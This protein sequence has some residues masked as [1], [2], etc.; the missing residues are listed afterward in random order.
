MDYY[1]VLGVPKNASQDQ[2]KKQYRKLSLEYHP[3]RPGGNANKFKDINEA[4]E[5]LSDANK[6]SQ[7]D[8]PQIDLM[9]ILGGMGMGGMGMGG[10][11]MGGMNGFPGFIFQHIMKPPPLTMTVTITLDQAYTGCKVPVKI[12]RWIHR[13]HIKELETE[14]CYV[15]IPQG[16]DSNECMLLMNKGH[17]GPDGAMGDVRVL[18][19]VA[20]HALTRKGLDLCFTQTITLKEALCGFSFEL[21]YLQ[22]KTYQIKNAKGNLIHPTYQK[23]IP[24]MGMKREGQVGQLIIGFDIHFPTLTEEVIDSI[25]KLL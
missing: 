6:R 2:I 7:Y 1:A 16:I 25:E 18:I 10:N 21:A 20:P 17:M 15:D 12:E 3:D 23:I 5:T 19:Q 14:T 11:G 22:G 8:S 4:Y 9:D 24:G 13:N